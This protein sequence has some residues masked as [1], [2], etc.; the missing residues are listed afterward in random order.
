MDQQAPAMK[1]LMQHLPLDKDIDEGT[2]AP[3]STP[4]RHSDSESSGPSRSRSPPKIVSHFMAHSLG[5]PLHASEKTSSVPRPVSGYGTET[6]S[7]EVDD[8]TVTE[9][10]RRASSIHAGDKRGRRHILRRGSTAKRHS[11]RS[12]D[13]AHAGGDSKKA[14]YG[15][16][17]RLRQSRYSPTIVL[18]N[19]GSVARDH[20]ASERTFLAYVRTSMGLASMGVA[21]VQLFAIADITSHVTG[22]KVPATSPNVQRFARPLGALTIALS[23][24]VLF[25][26]VW[27]YFK[28]QFSLP[29]GYFPVARVSAVFTSFVFTAIVVTIFGAV[30][31]GRTVS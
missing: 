20:L 3:S 4:I 9:E 28:I 8:S 22:G 12:S 15:W 26:G 25:I 14:K 16:I 6:P 18:K 31:S 2:C 11:K 23:L 10:K 29:G 21:L 13:S 5:A 19:S 30:L 1:D 27:R 7:E 17:R 24:V